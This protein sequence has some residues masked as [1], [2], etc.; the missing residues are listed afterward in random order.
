MPLIRLKVNNKMHI[1]PID[2]RSLSLDELIAYFEKLGEKP[3]R[4][5]QV[6]EWLWKKQ[7]VSFDEMTNLSLTLR[8]LLQQHFLIRAVVV[9]DHQISSDKTIKNAFKLYDGSIVEGVLIPTSSGRMTAC[10]SS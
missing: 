3:Y 9:S 5:K 6:Y 1:L 8:E 7:A 10:I 4:A 2:I